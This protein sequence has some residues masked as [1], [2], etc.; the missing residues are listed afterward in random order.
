MSPLD[1]KRDYMERK[2]K[3]PQPQSLRAAQGAEFLGV[4][5]ATFW[6]WAR[7]RPDFPQPIRLS[8][9][10]T[11]FDVEAL[12]TWRDAQTQAKGGSDGNA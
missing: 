7:T 11:V 6:R 3:S 12:R 1:A 4:G 8:P 2:V 9:R 10:C 5:V